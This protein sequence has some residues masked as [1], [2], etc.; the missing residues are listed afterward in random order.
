MTNGVEDP[1]SA[2]SDYER[3]GGGPAVAEVVDAFYQRVLADDALA[4]YFAGVD[5]ARLERHQAL[6]V[7]QVM[8]G[9][10]E[11]DGRDLRT[12]HAGLRVTDGDFDRV[13]EHLVL[14]LQGAGAPDDVIGRVGQALAGT[15]GDV[16]AG[17]EP[18]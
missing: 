4:P 13:V 7:S 15:R 14:T 8:G 5:L 2:P 3:V 17:T 12:A 18:A 10:V 11:Y 16:V 6:L 1:R 9:P